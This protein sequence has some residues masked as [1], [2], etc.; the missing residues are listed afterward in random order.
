MHAALW[1]KAVL[2]DVFF[3]RV[4]AGVLVGRQ[5]LQLLPRN[6][7][8][9]STLALAD[10]A[11]AGRGTCECSFNLERNVPAVAASLVEQVLSP[12]KASSTQIVEPVA[13]A[14]PHV[15]HGI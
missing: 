14:L 6:E 8:H 9:E 15:L 3:E 7:P 5:K 2:D 13:R 4:R 11:I 1:T 10:G 12:K